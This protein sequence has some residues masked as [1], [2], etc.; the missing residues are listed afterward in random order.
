[1]KHQVNLQSILKGEVLS[2]PAIDRLVS[3]FDEVYN[4]GAADAARLIGQPHPWWWPFKSRARKVSSNAEAVL[5]RV[6]LSKDLRR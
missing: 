1:M 6:Q 5:R 4:A 2:K 3:A